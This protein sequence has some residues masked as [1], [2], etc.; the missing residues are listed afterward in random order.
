MKKKVKL[1]ALKVESFV[2]K[3]DGQNKNEVLGG[4][5]YDSYSRIIICPIDETF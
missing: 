3:L 4:A 2:T 5:K 1:E